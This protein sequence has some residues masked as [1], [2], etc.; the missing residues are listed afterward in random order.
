MVKWEICIVRVELFW[1][2]CYTPVD[3]PTGSFVIFPAHNLQYSWGIWHFNKHMCVS[4]LSSEP[5]TIMHFVLGARLHFWWDQFF[6]RPLDASSG[7]LLTIYRT[8]FCK[9]KYILHFWLKLFKNMKLIRG[10]R[11]TLQSIPQD[12][13]SVKDIIIKLYYIILLLFCWNFLL[14]ALKNILF[15]D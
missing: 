12:L 13:G 3:T 6:Y 1:T 9:F 7:V 8:G 15:L 5:V 14:Y 4:S 10:R 11:S 2:G